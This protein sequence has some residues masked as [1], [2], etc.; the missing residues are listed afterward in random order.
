MGAVP[1]SVDRILDWIVA[2]GI[3]GGDE[4][5]LLYGFCR[6]CTAAGLAVSRAAAVIDTLHPVYEGRAFYWDREESVEQPVVEYG[7][8]N[9]GQAAEDWQRSTF[10]RLWESGGSEMRFRLCAG[11]TGGFPVLGELQA[12]GQTD[13]LLLIHR[14]S[15]EAAIGEMDCFFSRW[16]TDKPGGFDEDD[17]AALRRLAPA[18]GL[19]IKAQSL[20][21]VAQS[22]VEAYLGRDAGKRVLEG[23]IQ[24]GVTERIHAALWFSDM[25]GFTSMSEQ[26]RSDQL[27]PLLNDYAEAVISSIQAAGGDVLKLIGDGVLAIFTGDDPEAACS[28]ALSAE[29]GMRENLR[30]LDARRTADGE[31]LAAIYLGLHIGDVF[32]GNIGSRNRLDFTVVGPAVNETNRISSMCTSTGRLLL[33][34]SEFKN[35]LPAE[36]RSDFVSVG[37]YALR[38]VGR[39]QELFTL[40]PELAG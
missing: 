14:F 27:I 8:S 22:L 39:A 32:Y 5:S 20:V 18:L 10:F 21:R 29:R 31:P 36:S 34:S 26:L 40:D 35:A 4:L 12:Q 38:G 7:S 13:Y 15:K 6:E 24:R 2:R 23:R 3:A 9:E 33:V 19:A 1:E 17:I 30:A 16:T 28:A 37:R 11:E 25:H